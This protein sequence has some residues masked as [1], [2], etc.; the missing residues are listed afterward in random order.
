MGYVDYEWYK[1]E[2]GGK[3]DA[4]VFSQ[5]IEKASRRIDIHTTGIDGYRKLQEAFPINVYDENAVK[6]CA[7][8]LVD[9]MA[10]INT[11]K[12]NA[13]AKNGVISREDGSVTG[14]VISSVSSGSES[15]SYA[16]PENAR[17]KTAVSEAIKSV[18]SE[19]DLY[20]S[21]I[22]SALSGVSDR[23]GVNLLYMGR[24]PRV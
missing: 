11:E 10:Q 7:C 2:Y 21:F 23:N 4:S 18:Q 6:L 14:K 19:N 17:V 3:I 13:Y 24:Y 22:I 20:C 5:N 15:I 16:T 8:E 12:A 9:I 1:K